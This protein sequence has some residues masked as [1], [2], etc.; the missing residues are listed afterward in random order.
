M[1]RNAV[2]T[3]VLINVILFIVQISFR[4]F[5]ESF[6]LVSA[7][8]WTRPWII[9]TSMFLHGGLAHL[10]FNM[11][12]LYLFGTL[13]ERSIGT[14]K[15]LAVYFLA[16]ILAALLPQYSAALGASGAIMGI[17]G[18]VIMLFPDLRI[19]FFFAIPM[20]MRTAGI[21]FAAIEVFGLLVPVNTGIAHYAHL[22]G[23]A[24]GLAF[25]YYLIK[26]KGGVRRMVSRVPSQSDF[27]RHYGR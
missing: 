4:G 22:V 24:V 9:I 19:L 25:G 11:Y 2:T 6:M 3:L 23:L 10:F 20:S 26:K 7:D 12:A 13:V 27:D 14:K 8:I 21:I 5:T 18:I 1:R 17:L 15:F 16:G